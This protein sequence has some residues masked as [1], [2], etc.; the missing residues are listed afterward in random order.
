MVLI[1]VAALAASGLV[2]WLCLPSKDGKVLWDPMQEVAAAAITAG[3]GI[4]I[5]LLIAGIAQQDYW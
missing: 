2:L 3:F 1:A 4:G 5:V